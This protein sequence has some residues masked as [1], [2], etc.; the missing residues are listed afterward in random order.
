[1]NADSNISYV[2]SFMAG[3][4]LFFSPCILPLIPSYLSYLTGISFKELS[5]DL[6]SERKREIRILTILHSLSFILGFSLIF[7]TLGMTVT[8]LGRFLLEYQLLLKKIGATLIIFFGLLIAG[9]FKIGFLQKEKRITYRKKGTGFLGSF[10]V[11]AIFAFAWTP[12][13]GPILGSILVYA[14]STASTKL[15]FKLL[16]IF[17][18]GLALPFFASSLLLN[19]FLL[20]FNKI[21]G[22]LKWINLIAGTV[23]VIFGLLILFGRV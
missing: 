2:V 18:L 20:Y 7:V 8:F 19:S 1:M 9:I 11:G 5:G 4:L 15:G 6:S 22:L 12:C 13:V 17:S 21:K 14:S 23:L 3:S 16:S 10:L